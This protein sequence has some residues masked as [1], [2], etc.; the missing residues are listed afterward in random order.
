MYLIGILQA[1]GIVIGDTLYNLYIKYVSVNF[2]IRAFAFPFYYLIGNALT[3]MVFAGP[4]RFAL[5]TVK[6]VSTWVYGI[7]YLLSFVVEVYLVKY[8][9]STELSILLRLTV[10]VCILLS[11]IFNKRVPSKY[12]VISMSTILIAMSVIFA[13]QDPMYLW[14]ILFL[15]IALAF[16]EAMGYFIPENHS[17]NEKAIK[18]SGI[19]GQMRVIS[20]ATFI[21]STLMFVVLIGICFVDSNFDIFTKLGFEEKLIK[22]SDFV[23]LP[24]VLSGIIFGCII[25]PFIR[26]FQWSASYKITSEGVLTILAIIPLVT[27]SLEWILVTTGLSPSSYLFESNDKYI[28]FGLSVL[29]AVGSWYAAY[30]KA[31]S[32]LSEVNGSNVFE[33]L[34]NALKVKEKVLNIGHSVNSMQDYEVVKITVDFYEKNFEEASKVL[35]IP[36]ETLKTLYYG[37]NN[38][39][40]TA[41]YSKKVHDIFINKI[42]YLDQLTKLENRK[43][44]EAYFDE[45]KFENI[46]FSLYYMDLNGFKFINDT[47]GHNV[48]DEILIAVSNRLNSFV[49]GKKAK[50]YRFGGDEF[51]MII[52]SET[53]EA[54][55]KEEIKAIIEKPV[56]V[57]ETDLVETITPKMSIGR[58]TIL[59]DVDSKI[60]DL[61]QQADDQMYNEKK[62]SKKTV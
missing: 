60:K 24:T 3:M 1:F 21:T 4:G 56:E 16:L 52:A 8:V 12:D 51:A 58:S 49:I 36:A 59:K 55:I 27:F 61:L 44:F 47:Y 57:L 34:K 25:A 35:Q 30:L 26:F 28:L 19:R 13:L 5:D 9:S 14:N 53:D 17:T 20:F 39:S 42:F 15:C 50:A 23:H 33:K 46:N 48:G 32:N 43:G 54:L 7:A 41:E 37:Q 6:N 38:Y 62:L 11:F 22:Y 18:E 29:M 45:L 10:P 40:L 2:D 31:R